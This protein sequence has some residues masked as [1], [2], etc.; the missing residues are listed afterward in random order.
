[1]LT[2]SLQCLTFFPYISMWSINLT[3][4]SPL[5]RRCASMLAATKCWCQPC[6]LF[7][8]STN[9][10]AL[11]IETTSNPK[12]ARSRLESHSRKFSSRAPLPKFVAPSEVDTNPCY[13]RPNLIFSKVPGSIRTCYLSIMVRLP[14]VS[15]SQPVWPHPWR[16]LR[17]RDLS[18]EAGRQLPH[19]HH[20]VR[21]LLFSSKCMVWSY[22]HYMP[23]F[24]SLCLS[25]HHMILRY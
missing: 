23:I 16:S 3:S 22:I 6:S 17:L 7:E 15:V 9:T 18:V 24:I 11:S 20:A 14:S 12:Q 21:L 1:M 2:I 5:H 8:I 13:G 25:E 4:T 19:Q 10:V